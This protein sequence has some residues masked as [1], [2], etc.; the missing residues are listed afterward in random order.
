MELSEKL[1]NFIKEQEWIFAKTYA[2]T[3]PHEYIVQERVDHELFLEL[4]NH[5]DQF[6]YEDYFY[7]VKQIYFNFDDNA[8]WHMDN[9]INRCLEKETY[10]HR[11]QE[12]RLPE[13]K[14]E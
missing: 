12:G 7:K 9:I 13:D 2:E 1:K 8:Y 10:S 11:K 4:A 14:R 5:I 3:W 6:G